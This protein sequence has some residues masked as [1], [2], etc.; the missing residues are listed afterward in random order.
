M[1]ISS[2][3]TKDG[4]KKLAGTKGY[5]Y[6]FHWSMHRMNYPPKSFAL[7]ISVGTK[8]LLFKHRSYSRVE[9]IKDGF[10]VHVRVTKT[11]TRTD[12]RK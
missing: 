11:L 6:L 1:Y 8:Q 5:V 3:K 9:G 10:R 2:D 7:V 4:E 12:S